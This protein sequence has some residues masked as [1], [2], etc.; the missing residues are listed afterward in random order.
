MPGSNEA[1]AKV[2]AYF[3]KLPDHARRELRVLRDAIRDAAP[4]VVDAFGYGLPGY[5]LDGRV[6]IWYAAWKKHSSIYPLSDG[7]KRKFA[8][9]LQGYATSKGTLRLPHDKPIPVSLIKK[10]V[11]A[12]IADLK[13]KARDENPG[14]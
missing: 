5:K 8:K 9:E 7:A 12:R 4:G 2:K 3:A 10:I 6:L 13:A 1:S 11:K 14:E